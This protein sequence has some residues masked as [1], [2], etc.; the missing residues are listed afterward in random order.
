MGDLFNDNFDP[1]SL[2]GKL[3]GLDR[4]D[5]GA[6]LAK[7]RMG[8]W[9]LVMNDRS[10][11]GFTD[12]AANAAK[13]WDKIEEEYKTYEDELDEPPEDETSTFFKELSRQET[14]RNLRKTGNRGFVNSSRGTLL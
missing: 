11:A 5:D 10:G 13:N 9:A 1:D 3:K 8:A 14:E 6:A 2:R 7:K 12:T 4:D